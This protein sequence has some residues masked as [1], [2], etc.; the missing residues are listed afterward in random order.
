[1]YSMRPSVSDLALT[2]ATDRNL[3]GL[4][5]NHYFL[6]STSIVIQDWLN[7]LFS[8][9]L[10]LDILEGSLSHQVPEEHAEN[11][12]RAQAE[13]YRAHAFIKP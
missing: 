13:E 12:V 5:I 2:K 6:N 1:M 8:S 3:L 10:V 11:G 9:A 4:V 7:I